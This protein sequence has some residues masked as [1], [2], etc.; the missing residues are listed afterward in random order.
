MKIEA[1]GDE[2]ILVALSDK[3]MNELD[4]TYDEMDYSN[5]ETRRVIWTILDEAKRSLGKNIDTDGKILIEVTQSDDGGCI[6]CFTTMPFTDGKSRKKLIMK[7]DAE[8][9][10]FKALD[11]DAFLDAIKVLEKTPELY[12]EFRLFSYCKKLYFII[13]PKITGGARI[14]YI[15]SDFGDIFFNESELLNRIF[16]YGTPLKRSIKENSPDFSSTENHF[17]P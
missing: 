11:S 7:K 17:K 14:S 8:P 3:D 5:I 13:Y 10:I 6:M 12:K 2:K 4:I 16:E 1:I 9:V 15:L